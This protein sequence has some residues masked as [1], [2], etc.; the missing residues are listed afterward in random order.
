MMDLGIQR[1]GEISEIAT[2]PQ[3]RFGTGFL[4]DSKLPQHGHRSARLYQGKI[5]GAVNDR[6]FGKRIWKDP[7]RFIEPS[8]FWN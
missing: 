3:D 6:T 5:A 8:H 2:A 7:D 1:V 4:I